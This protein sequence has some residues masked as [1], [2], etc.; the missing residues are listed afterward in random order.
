[1]SECGQHHRGRFLRHRP[2]ED[3]TTTALALELPAEVLE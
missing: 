1:M 2:A 3:L